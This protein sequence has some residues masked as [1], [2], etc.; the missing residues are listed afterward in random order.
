MSRT[1]AS[2]L[3]FC[4]TAAAF[5]VWFTFDGTKQRTAAIYVLMFVNKAADTTVTSVAEK[6]QL[7][8][9]TTCQIFRHSHTQNRGTQ[10]PTDADADITEIQTETKHD[11]ISVQD[12]QCSQGHDDK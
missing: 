11:C 9:I 12:M 5:S 2:Y 10:A 4:L 1:C 8:A 7:T 3:R 6:L